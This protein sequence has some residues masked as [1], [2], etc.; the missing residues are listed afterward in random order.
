MG[1]LK[2][3]VFFPQLHFY[4][5][6]C[7]EQPWHVLAKVCGLWLQM[8]GLFISIH[9]LH[10]SECLQLQQIYLPFGTGFN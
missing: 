5:V 7:L 8:P 3:G 6:R 9:L 4:S 1:K 2:I 10:V